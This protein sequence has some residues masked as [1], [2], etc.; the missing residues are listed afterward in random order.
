VANRAALLDE[1]DSYTSVL[2]RLRTAIEAGDGATLEA[3]FARSRAA[4]SE[5]QER[6]SSSQPATRQPS[7]TRSAA[8]D[9]SK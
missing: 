4:R 9:A 5:W 3:V 6:A 2:A 8:D 7:P 1:I